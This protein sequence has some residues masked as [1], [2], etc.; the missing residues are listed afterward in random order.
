MSKH[1]LTR[2]E[3]KPALPSGYARIHKD[4]VEMLDTARHAT[5]RN[6]NALMR[7]SYWKIG[8]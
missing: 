1:T 7:A 8:R 3:N 4:I 5:A 6:V 2:V